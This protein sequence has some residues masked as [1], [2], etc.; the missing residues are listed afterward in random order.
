MNKKKKQHPLNNPV[1]TLDDAT[2]A[3][4]FLSDMSPYLNSACM[5][6]KGAHGLSVIFGSIE[7]SIECAVKAL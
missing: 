7:K 3:I 4:R 5:S 1:D 2:C 6:E